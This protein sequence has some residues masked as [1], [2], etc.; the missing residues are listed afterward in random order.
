MRLK[1]DKDA[2]APRRQSNTHRVERPQDVKELPRDRCTLTVLT[3]AAPGTVFTVDRRLVLGRDEGLTSRIDDRGVSG[4]H[5]CIYREAGHFWLADLDSTNGT[6][7]QGQ[8]LSDL[9]AS[10]RRPHRAR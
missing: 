6:Y 4:Q 1:T 5:A 8:R 9:H 7:V 10:R 2:R 3:G